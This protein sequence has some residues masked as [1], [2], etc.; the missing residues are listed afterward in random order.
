MQ[1]VWGAVDIVIQNAIVSDQKTI[2]R[3]VQDAAR[4]LCARGLC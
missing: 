2:A 1:P 4:D 3:A